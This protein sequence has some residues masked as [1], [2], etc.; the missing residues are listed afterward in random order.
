VNWRTENA[1][2]DLAFE[3]MKAVLLSFYTD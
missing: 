1:D 2:V 3:E